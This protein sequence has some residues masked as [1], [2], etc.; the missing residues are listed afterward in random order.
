M[1]WYSRL[2][3]NSIKLGDLQLKYEHG[4]Q[5]CSCHGDLSVWAKS[6]CCPCVRPG[7]Q[8]ASGPALP[9]LSLLVARCQHRASY[10][11]LRTTDFSSLP[12]P[13]APGTTPRCGTEIP[14]YSVHVILIQAIF[15]K[16]VHANWGPDCTRNIPVLSVCK[17]QL[18]QCHIHPLKIGLEEFPVIHIPWNCV[19]RTVCQRAVMLV[20]R[21]ANLILGIYEVFFSWGGVASELDTMRCRLVANLKVVAALGASFPTEWHLGFVWHFLS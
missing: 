6:S 12:P 13:S 7:W 15:V 21:T 11:H 14:L 1:L 8:A 4:L 10:L 5:F 2:L 18:P 16:T 17:F 19:S 3:W 9:H 20:R